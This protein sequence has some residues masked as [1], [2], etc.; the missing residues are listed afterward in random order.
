MRGKLFIQ[1][2]AL[3]YYLFLYNKI[4]DVRTALSNE[5]K[6]SNTTKTKI[7]KLKNLYSWMTH[8]SLSQILVW[9]D[10]RYEMTVKSPKGQSRWASEITARD[11]FFLERLGVTSCN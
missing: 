5:I 4:D 10:C 3:S 1:F 11:N 6:N 8:K 9:F 7:E 2:I